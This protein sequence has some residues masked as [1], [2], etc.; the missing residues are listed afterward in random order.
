M[1]DFAAP[2]PFEPV[3]TTYLH[4]RSERP[5]AP[6]ASH[7][8][9]AKRFAEIGLGLLLTVGFVA[10][11]FQTRA[12]WAGHRDWVVPAL[13][14]PTAMAA[15]ALAGL[16]MRKQI[17]AAGP[18]LAFLVLGLALTVLNIAIDGSDTLQNVLSIITAV[19]LG[20]AA[21]LLIVAFVVVEW[22]HPIKAPA[23]EM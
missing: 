18:G 22:K 4:D 14:V 8:T 15:I 1:A 16:L 9:T 3:K 17:V 12:A 10:L 11:C 7:S 13:V 19:L 21:M 23:P 6:A 2:A 20:I 5:K